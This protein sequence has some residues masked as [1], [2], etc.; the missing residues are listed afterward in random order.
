MTSDVIG[1]VKGL[2]GRSKEVQCCHLS[3]VASKVINDREYKLGVVG[4]NLSGVTTS[5]LHS[6][7]LFY[8]CV[9]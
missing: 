5:D 8:Q 2:G 6:S 7:L 9:K 4:D 1:T 3:A